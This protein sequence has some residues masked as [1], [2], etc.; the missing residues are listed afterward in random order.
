M[1]SDYFQMCSGPFLRLVVYEEFYQDF[2]NQSGLLDAAVRNEFL[3]TLLVLVW[4]VLE[5]IGA[6]VVTVSCNI[7]CESQEQS[8]Q[9]YVALELLT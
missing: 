1:S 8:V 6:A 3:L 2:I 5:L 7:L 9:C 4:L